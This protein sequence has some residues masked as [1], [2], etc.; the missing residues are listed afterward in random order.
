MTIASFFFFCIA[1]FVYVASPGPA[2]LILV[3]HVLSQGSKGVS[4]FITGLLIS[5]LVWFMFTAMG[6]NWITRTFYIAFLAI[7]YIGIA[8]LLYLAFRFWNTPAHQS[9]ISAFKIDKPPLQQ[10]LGG[11]VISLGN[12]IVM[13]FYLALLPIVVNPAKLN[14][15]EFIQIAITII[16]I[17]SIVFITYALIAKR[18]RRMLVS[19]H[20]LRFLNRG[21]GTA[22]IAIAVAVATR[23]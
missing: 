21:S 5:D 3:T 14:V 16:S 9:K 10:F 7:K 17:R 1:N 2:S 23:R 13:T 8:Y 18:M 6:L 12:P 4:S 11:L 20:T 15:A 19:P 22:M